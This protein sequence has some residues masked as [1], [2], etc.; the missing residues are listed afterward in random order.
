MRK[1]LFATNNA[2]KIQEAQYRIGSIFQVISL[3][4]VGINET[5]PEPYDTLKEN[6]SAKSQYIYNKLHQNCFSE[7]TGLF[8]EAL[9][10]EPGVHSARYAGEQAR[11]TANLEK[12][13]HKM[14]GK[15]NRKAHFSTIISLIMDGK[16]YFFEGHC[17]GNIVEIANGKMGFG[18]DPVFKPEGSEKTFGEMDIDEKNEFSHRRKALDLLIDFLTRITPKENL[19]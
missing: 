6:A 12:L 15:E 9:H 10:G 4:E 7:D 3:K 14:Y 11:D 13:V 8:V 5:I 19:S 17:K 16:E 18:Y 2:H 1:I